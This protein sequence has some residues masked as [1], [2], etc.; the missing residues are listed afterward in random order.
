MS[1]LDDAT[2]DALERAAREC[3]HAHPTDVIR[4][5]EEVRLYKA[6]MDITSRVIG[7]DPRTEPGSSLQGQVS[8]PPIDYA[9]VVNGAEPYAPYRPGVYYEEKVRESKSKGRV[10][11]GMVDC[12]IPMSPEDAEAIT[13]ALKDGVVF[14]G[15]KITIPKYHTDPTVVGKSHAELYAAFGLPEPVDPEAPQSSPKSDG[16]DEPTI[17]DPKDR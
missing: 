16:A 14:H 4:L 8:T 5:V 7:Y 1:P 11:A 6:W 12:V 13:K 10:V 17:I 9:E 2:L 3:D 15:P